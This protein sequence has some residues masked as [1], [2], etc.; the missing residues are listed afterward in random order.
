MHQKI[1]NFKQEGVLKQHV[2]FDG[3][4]HDVLILSIF[5]EDF[6]NRNDK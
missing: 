6:L 1:G 2:F 3:E 5:K 4:Y